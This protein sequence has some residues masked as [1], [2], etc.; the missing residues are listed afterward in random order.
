M[1]CATLKAG[2]ACTFMTAKGC[3]FSGGACFTVIEQCEGCDR[4]KEFSSGKY[5]ISFP[6]PSQKWKLGNCNLA[7][8]VKKAPV[9]TATKVNPL[10]ASKRSA[11]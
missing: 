9:Q 6:N 4:N 8:H 1:D 2:T 3:S 11:R 5:C 10:K 7:T